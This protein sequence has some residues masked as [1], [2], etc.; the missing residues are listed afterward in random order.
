MLIIKVTSIAEKVPHFRYNSLNLVCIDS[1]GSKKYGDTVA[2]DIVYRDCEAVFS[3][4]VVHHAQL[5][6]LSCFNLKK[7]LRF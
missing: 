7:S 3:K 4:Q 1:V 5:F 2:F 6:Q